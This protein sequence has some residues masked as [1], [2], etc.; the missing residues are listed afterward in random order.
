MYSYSVDVFIQDALNADASTANPDVIGGEYGEV[1]LKIH[2]MGEEAVKWVYLHR[3]A[4]PPLDSHIP[5]G[6]I[7]EFGLST[8]IAP[9]TE[10]A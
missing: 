4:K 9:L 2:V 3:A 10:I 7:A 8:N 6:K 1:V 5:I